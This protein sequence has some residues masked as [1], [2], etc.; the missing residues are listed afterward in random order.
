MITRI[1]ARF[2]AADTA[3][4]LPR[5]AHDFHVNGYG[6]VSCVAHPDARVER[7]DGRTFVCS[8]RA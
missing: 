5:V 4:K 2:R 7:F 1:L 8:A 3:I 6:H